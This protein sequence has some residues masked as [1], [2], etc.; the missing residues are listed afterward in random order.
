MEHIIAK[1]PQDFE[2]GKSRGTPKPV[3]ASWIQTAF[4]CSS[5]ERAND[6]LHYDERHALLV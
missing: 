4:T 5:A 1:L 2:Q 3:S 6:A